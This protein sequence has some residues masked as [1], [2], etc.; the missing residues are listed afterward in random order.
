VLESIEADGM[1]FV[2]FGQM[3]NSFQVLLIKSVLVA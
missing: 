3:G 1:Q 2:R